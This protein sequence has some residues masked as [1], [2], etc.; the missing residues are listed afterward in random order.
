MIVELNVKSILPFDNNYTV[1]PES[2]PDNCSSEKTSIVILPSVASSI[3]SANFSA[4]INHVVDSLVVTDISKFISS[5]PPLADEPEAP[6]S[7]EHALI[8]NNTPN[9]NNKLLT[10]LIFVLPLP[11]SLF[12][13][14]DRKSV[15]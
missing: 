4:A 10:F 6:S 9:N 8:N 5:S 3:S 1:F 15:V 14:L 7:D 13:L 2:P 11:L 12:K